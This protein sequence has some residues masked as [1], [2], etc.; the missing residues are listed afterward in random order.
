MSFLT[1]AISFPM[2]GD[3]F[4]INPP[5]HLTVFGKSIYYYGIIIAVGFLLAVWYAMHRSTEFGLTEDNILDNLII[6]T[7]VSIIGARLYYVIFNPEGYFG[8]GNWKHII[9]I[10]NG[11]LAIYG[12]LIFAILTVLII[13]RRKKINVLALLDLVCIGFL[14]GQSIG[15]W[16]N[17]FNREAFGYE[18]EIFCRMGLQTASGSFVYVHPTFLYESVWNAVGFVILHFHSKKRR[19]NGEIFLMYLAWYGLGRYFIE[20]LRTDSLYIGQTDIRVSQLLAIICFGISLILLLR[21][22]ILKKDILKSKE[23]DQGS[24]IEDNNLPIT[25]MNTDSDPTAESINDDGN[26]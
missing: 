20:G 4:V 2:F 12:G 24:D 8:P 11:G 3:G 26:K 21:N 19:Y 22:L 25:T 23:L 1:A 9:E 17:F 16:G 15:R 7:P 5:T 13:C 6:A 10:W 18:T 14:I